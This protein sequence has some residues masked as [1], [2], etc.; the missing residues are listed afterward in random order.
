VSIFFLHHIGL[1]GAKDNALNIN[2]APNISTRKPI[3]QV[4]FEA[5]DLM[6]CKH[7]GINN[8]ASLQAHIILN[9]K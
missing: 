2:N 3:T 6:T 8:Q 4:L 1:T 7:N 5:Y 9:E